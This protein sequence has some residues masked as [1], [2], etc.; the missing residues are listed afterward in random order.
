[1]YGRKWEK[2]EIEMLKSD[3]TNE[4]I[5]KMTNRSE[6]SVRKKRYE[7]TGHY[8]FPGKDMTTYVKPKE[9][10]RDS[11][12]SGKYKELRLIALAE[13]LG[14]RLLGVNK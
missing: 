1:M 2:E 14:V 11:F 5:M 10:P 8:S 4:E 7:I 6:Y 12:T 13:K 3:M 9:R